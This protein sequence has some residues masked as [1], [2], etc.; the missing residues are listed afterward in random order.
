M[1]GSPDSGIFHDTHYL[2][3]IPQR[4]SLNPALRD[5][6]AYWC[7]SWADFKKS[8]RK[9]SV[10][11]LKTYGKA[12]QSLA[13]SLGGPKACTVE[14][15]AAAT[16]IEKAATFYDDG[17]FMVGSVSTQKLGIVEMIK[18]KGLPN[19]HDPLHVA[20]LYETSDIMVRF[21]SISFFL[22]YKREKQQQGT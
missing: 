21:S 14:T 5:S 12:L 15:I 3:H 8:L 19:F 16:L 22:K 20:L 7:S 1:E 11:T 18:R 13:K 2:E 17:L 6:V 4:I 10:A 9:P